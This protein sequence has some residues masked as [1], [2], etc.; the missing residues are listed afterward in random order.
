ML[1]RDCRVFAAVD[2]AV[3]WGWSESFQNKMVYLLEVLIWQN[4]TPQS[5]AKK[6]AHMGLKPELFKP[7]WQ[8]GHDEDGIKKDTVAADID[9]IKEILARPRN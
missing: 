2:P 6:A 4:A 5:P 3:Q 1:P 7:P 9:T 8:K